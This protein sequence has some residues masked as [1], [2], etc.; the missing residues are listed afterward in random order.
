[1]K[2]SDECR[3]ELRSALYAEL[4]ELLGRV[5]D[6]EAKFRVTWA[7]LRLRR[8]HAELMR[9]GEYLPLQVQGVRAAHV[10]AFAR[11]LREQWI[12][13]VAPRLYA[14]LGLD[15]GDAPIGPI[16]GDTQ[17]LLPEDAGEAAGQGLRLHDVLSGR[18]HLGGAEGLAVAQLLRDFPVALL[19]GGSGFA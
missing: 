1:M 16:W 6:G 11:R 10:V 15:V 18:D 4:R 3:V 13:V 19:S 14:S 2:L 9:D 17:L 8:A 5:A 12:I 7:A